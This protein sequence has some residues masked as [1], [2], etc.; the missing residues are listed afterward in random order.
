MVI[1]VNRNSY[2]EIT[3]PL[4]EGQALYVHVHIKKCVCT[5]T[6]NLIDIYLV[7]CGEG[8]IGLNKEKQSLYP[9]LFM[10]LSKHW[11]CKI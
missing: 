11:F 1:T 2:N 6:D 7:G 8:H 10:K 4:N 9:A 5:N 3:K